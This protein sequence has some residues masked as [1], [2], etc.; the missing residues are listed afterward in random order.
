MQYDRLSQQQLSFLYNVSSLPGPA[1][2]AC[3]ITAQ[4]CAL[5]LKLILRE[6]WHD[7]PTNSS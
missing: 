6:R 4:Y 7:R 1:N 2:D 5:R 3:H